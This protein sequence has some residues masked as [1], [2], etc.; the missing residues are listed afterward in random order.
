[1]LFRSK[2]SF[3]EVCSKYGFPLISKEVSE[4]VQGAR[5]YFTRLQQQSEILKADTN[6]NTKFHTF[7]E[8][9]DSQ[10]MTKMTAG[11]GANMYRKLRG[12]GEYDTMH[13]FST[14]NADKG[15]SDKGEYP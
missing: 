4:C 15:Q 9:L 13:S 3:A 14:R 1:M 10:A 7:L 6:I 12:I 5:R 2:I 11:G 8:Q